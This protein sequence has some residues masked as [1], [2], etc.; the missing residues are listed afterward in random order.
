MKSFQLKSEMVVSA[1]LLIALLAIISCAP[2]QGSQDV[3]AQS[4]QS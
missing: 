1:I 3:D 4:A 2:K